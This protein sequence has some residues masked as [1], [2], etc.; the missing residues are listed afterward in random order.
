MKIQYSIFNLIVTLFLSATCIAAV[1]CS[2]YDSDI[3][4]DINIKYGKIHYDNTKSNSQFPSKPYATTMGLT[5]SDLKQNFSADSHIVQTSDGSFCVSLKKVHANIGFPR[6]DIYIDKKY[7][8]GTCNYNVIKEHE[9]YH[10]RVQ[11]E[12]L[13]FFEP[14]IR[15]AIKIASK[16]IKAER[17]FSMDQAQAIA[18]S[19][20]DRI[21]RDIKPTMNFVQKRLTEENQVIDTPESYAAETKKC[22]RW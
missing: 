2:T 19:M 21:Q 22:K 16:K 17:A 13:Q 14:K 10:A 20:L 1:D 8:P 3:A 7:R 4:L 11:R 5:M 12:G 18:S 15:Q 6:I 9:E